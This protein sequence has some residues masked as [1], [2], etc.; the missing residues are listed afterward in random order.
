LIHPAMP[1]LEENTFMKSNTHQHILIIGSGTRE[2]AI[3]K[4]LIKSASPPVISCLGS[5]KNPGIMTIC[6]NS[7]GKYRKGNITSPE[8]VLAFAEELQI[9]LA[10][11][12][13]EAPLA[14]G[15]PDILR[16]HKFPVLGPDKNPAKIE[17][18]KSYARDFLY[19]IL[20]ESCPDFR[21]IYDIF[22]AEMYL[23]QLGDS[24]VIKAD[25]LTGGKGVK[26][27]GDHL[28]S[29]DEAMTYCREL[30]KPD[31]SH[32][33]IEEKLFGEE[34][35]LMTITDGETCIHMPAV[36]DH[37]R[38]Y[39]DDLGP[40][41]G[42]MGSYSDS[43]HNLPFLSQKDI[44]D[45]GR[46]NEIVVAA[47]CKEHGTPY[48]GILYGGF[49]AVAQGVKIIEYNARFGDPES[50]NLLTLLESDAVEL[51]TA[52]AC[53]K[54]GTVNVVFSRK[55]SVC[56]Y[57]VPQGYPESALKGSSVSTADVDKHDSV[58]IYLGSVDMKDGVLVTGGSRTAAVVAVGN[59]IAEAE[60]LAEAAVSSIEGNLFHRSDIGTAPSLE[61][62][63]C[64]MKS[65]RKNS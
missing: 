23:L 21:V 37:K 18:S 64:H 33:V 29:M 36:Q 41:T 32:M 14:A 38:A 22:E 3:A 62:R 57:A 24:Y 65:L 49:M 44:A 48:R 7:E 45:A 34:F 13:P 2:H 55:A 19:R 9:D 16:E 26:V 58:E 63:I 4:A 20:P 31:N 15:V 12:G 39:N 1:V 30:L 43:D 61:K 17:T 53:G 52:A 60:K 6:S 42:G 8:S 11:I 40:N 27:S 47:L 46:M 54:L 51:F 10:V 59:T 56:K 50:L 25:G 5:T 28:T 35:S